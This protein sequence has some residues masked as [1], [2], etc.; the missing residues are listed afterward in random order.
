MLYK[1]VCHRYF[2]K[3]NL[4]LMRCNTVMRKIFSL[5]YEHAFCSNFID[6]RKSTS[7]IIINC[8]LRKLFHADWILEY[9]LEHTH[10]Y[11]NVC[12]PYHANTWA[13]SIFIE[14]NLPLMRY[15]TTVVKVSA[16]ISSMFFCDNPIINK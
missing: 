11:I 1:Y 12:V 8:E 3:N 5:H 9:R 4:S 14:D 7:I 2:I 10:W 13:I 6:K 16:C 15:D